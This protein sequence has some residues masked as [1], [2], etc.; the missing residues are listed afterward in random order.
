MITR[1]PWLAFLAAVIPWCSHPTAGPLAAQLV[2]NAEP[3]PTRKFGKE[4]PTVDD[5]ATDNVRDLTRKYRPLGLSNVEPM[6]AAIL[7]DPR[8]RVRANAVSVLFDASYFAGHLEA[9]LPSLLLAL[10]DPHPDVTSRAADALAGWYRDHD[11]VRA[12][13]QAHIE[14]I[15][16]A[17][18]SSDAITQAHAVSALEKLGERP[19]VASILRAQNPAIRQRGVAQT[20]AAHDL[21]AVPILAELASTDPD[22]GVRLDAVRAV[23]ELAVPRVRDPLLAGLFNDPS[24]PVADAAIRVAGS[25]QATA[26]IPLLRQLL[27]A[28]LDNRTDA[29]IVALTALRD[30]EAISLIAAHLDDRSADV[31]WDA[32]LGLDGLVGVV[33]PLAEWQIWARKQGHL[34]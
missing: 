29:A 23:G 19:P 24:S 13:L 3:R 21:D 1:A 4:R 34:R 17:T 30:Q 26:L 9:A 14:H 31:K 28:P 2:S 7:S 8:P 10:D 5:L 22:A 6:A 27:V 20:V 16:A 18:A 33:R 32:K 25:A 15:R 11:G 12:A